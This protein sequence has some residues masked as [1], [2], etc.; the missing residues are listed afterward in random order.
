LIG[1]EVQTRSFKA[2]ETIFREGDP[3]DELY[4]IDATYGAPATRHKQSMLTM[5]RK[6]PGSSQLRIQGLA[7]GWLFLNFGG[8]LAPDFLTGD[9]AATCK[10]L[11]A[12][13]DFVV[14]VEPIARPTK[15]RIH[16]DR[17]FM[18]RPHTE[19]PRTTPA[20]GTV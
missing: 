13:F 10:L 20:V 3:A 4:V 15:T 12:F 5:S 8:N 16:Y 7:R 6:L 17:I 18:R 11:R 9:I 14:S 1:K 19:L 2:G